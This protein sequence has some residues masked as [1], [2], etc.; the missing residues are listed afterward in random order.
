MGSFAS[1]LAGPQH[2]R[3]GGNLGNSDCPFLLIAE[4]CLAVI[5][6]IH[7]ACTSTAPTSRTRSPRCGSLAR[8]LTGKTYAVVDTNGLPVHFALG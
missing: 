6:G 1:I 2:A 7:R 5:L 8:G 3:L 4:V